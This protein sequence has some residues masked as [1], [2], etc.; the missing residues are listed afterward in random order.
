[1]T[2]EVTDWNSVYQHRPY[3]EKEPHQKIVWLDDLFRARGVQRILDLGCGDGRHL[4]YFTQQGYTIYGLDI[5]PWGVRR[6][7]EWL[8]REGLEAGLLCGDMIALPWPNESLDAVFSIQVI[9][10]NKLALI[11]KTVGEI[12]R[13][14]RDGGFFFATWL[15]YPPVDSRMEEADEIEP[16][17]FVRREGFE[18]GLPHHFFTEGEL[19]ELLHRFDWLKF[20]GTASGKYY[21]VLAQRRN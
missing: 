10:H 12:Y 1:M 7:Q 2:I 14:L 4:V 18:K 16:R 6:A 21:D 3:H 17:T 13:I 15:K 20:E 9:Y 8:N 19:E 5:A 11:R